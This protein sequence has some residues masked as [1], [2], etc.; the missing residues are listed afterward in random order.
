MV[1]EAFRDNAARFVWTCGCAKLVPAIPVVETMLSTIDRRLVF[2][3]IVR[4]RRV[5]EEEA[6]YIKTRLVVR[7]LC[8]AITVRRVMLDSTY[9]CVGQPLDIR[10]ISH[11]KF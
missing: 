6:D 11:L 7:R 3:T 9:T 4:F 10:S 2:G 8:K 1:R 5:L